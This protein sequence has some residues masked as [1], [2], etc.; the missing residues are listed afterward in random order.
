[1]TKEKE[2][3][4]IYIVC[5]LVILIAVYNSNKHTSQL[6]TDYSF[7]AGKTLEYKYADGFKDCIEYKY[8]V[9]SL[10]YIGCVINDSNISSVKNKFYR[11]KYSNVNPEIS[12]LYLTNEIKD[13]TKIYNSGFLHKWRRRGFDNLHPN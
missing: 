5:A 11:V 3:N 6:K 13:S 4:I 10:K 2:Q 1:M 7:T 8:F 12:E 9:D